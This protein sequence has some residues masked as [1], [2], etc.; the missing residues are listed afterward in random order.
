MRIRLSDLRRIIREEV[1]K[2]VEIGPGLPSRYHPAAPDSG[3][4]SAAMSKAGVPMK[5]PEVK[6]ALQNAIPDMAKNLA[7]EEMTPEELNAFLNDIIAR[8]KE[9]KTFRTESRSR[10]S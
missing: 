5:A 7:A 2:V 8:S 1:E 6:A 3:L 4:M 9:A 10:R